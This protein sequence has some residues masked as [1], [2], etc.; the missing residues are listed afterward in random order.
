MNFII[1][2][3]GQRF[4]PAGTEGQAPCPLVTA[5]YFGPNKKISLSYQALGGG[6]RCQSPDQDLD[7]V[8]AQVAFAGIW[9]DA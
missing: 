9:G 3:G 2:K 8:H 6:A 1:V 7:Q 5:V 4:F